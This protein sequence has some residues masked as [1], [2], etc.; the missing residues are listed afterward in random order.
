MPCNIPSLFATYGKEPAQRQKI[1]SKFVLKIS[2]GLKETSHSHN[3]VK[4]SCI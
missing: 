1:I 4:Q 3:K 2:T